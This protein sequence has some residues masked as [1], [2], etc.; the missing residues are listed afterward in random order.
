MVIT[1]IF[2]GIQIDNI[3]EAAKEF[4][5]K[6]DPAKKKKAYKFKKG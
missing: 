5:A 3:M 4:V 1:A 2:D 6:W